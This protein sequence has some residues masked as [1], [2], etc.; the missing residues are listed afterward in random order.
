MQQ[1]WY[2]LKQEDN[3]HKVAKS[4]FDINH[5]SGFRWWHFNSKFSLRWEGSLNTPVSQSV[6]GKRIIKTEFYR[7]LIEPSSW[8][9]SQYFLSKQAIRSVPV[10]MQK[11]ISTITSDPLYSNT[12]SNTYIYHLNRWSK[13]CS[14]IYFAFQLK[15]IKMCIC[16]FLTQWPIKTLSI[17]SRKIKKK[18][19]L[20]AGLGCRYYS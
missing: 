10:I 18:L 11:Y 7:T 3:L 14:N 8:E 9:V 1:T 6:S 16:L 4:A 5:V 2:R 17:K 15:T 19:K 13:N 20:R 12:K